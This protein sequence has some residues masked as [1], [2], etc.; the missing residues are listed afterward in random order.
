MGS[1]IDSSMIAKKLEVSLFMP[2]GRETGFNDSDISKQSFDSILRET[3]EQDFQR[4]RNSNSIMDRRSDYQA[5]RERQTTLRESDYRRDIRNESR[6]ENIG[7]S[8]ER[9]SSRC[10]HNEQSNEKNDIAPKNATTQESE[11]NYEKEDNKGTDC[12]E[13]KIVESP[14]SESEPKKDENCEQV[15]SDAIIPLMVMEDQNTEDISGQNMQQIMPESEEL[16]TFSNSACSEKIS[17]AGDSFTAEQQSPNIHAVSDGNAVV[18]QVVENG[19]ASDKV[20]LD[21]SMINSTIESTVQDQKTQEKPIVAT[22]E[23]ES[24]GEQVF[25]ND[26]IQNKP[27]AQTDETEK[28]DPNQKKQ[29]DELMNEDI[30]E[31]MGDDFLSQ[32]SDDKKTQQNKQPYDNNQARQEKAQLDSQPTNTD[33][34]AGKQTQFKLD[35]HEQIKDVSLQ[36]TIQEKSATSTE[37]PALNDSEVKKSVDILAGMDQTKKDSVEST[38]SKQ[39][40]SATRSQDYKAEEQEIMRQVQA[41]LSLRT[42]GDVTRSEIKFNLYPKHLGEVA[43]KLVMQDNTL[44]ARMRVDNESVKQTLE[45]NIADLRRN[46]M[47]QGVKV[48]KIEVT[49]KSDTQNMGSFDDRRASTHAEHKGNYE[50]ITGGSHRFKKGDGEDTIEQPV[51][52]MSFTGQQTI[53]TDGRL[54]Y[55]A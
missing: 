4:N 39:D 5:G 35:N 42:M 45:S 11:K 18:A 22:L 27:V 33:D 48:E 2:A 7:R 53:K 29:T 1:V 41:K 38:Q 26:A 14:Q 54:N 23:G 55:L 43:M 34:T 9:S 17:E 52:N 47:N 50:Y 24:Q 49:V 30:D 40:T 8:D 10:G 51:K 16:V 36:Q 46:L 15:A 19:L 25:K 3:V 12:S 32:F 20:V 44:V 6:R 28:I 13:N 37:T 21:D 31:D